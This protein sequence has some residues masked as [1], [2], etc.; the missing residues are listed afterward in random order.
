MTWRL[1]SPANATQRENASPEQEGDGPLFVMRNRRVERI[2]GCV[3]DEM[4]LGAKA[5]QPIGSDAINPV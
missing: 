4:Q 5:S 2:V 1:M 3:Y